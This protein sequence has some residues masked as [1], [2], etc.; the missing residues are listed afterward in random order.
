[1]ASRDDSR[2]W[3]IL[4]GDALSRLRD[5]PSNSV[6]CAVT[7]PP[8]WGLRD[9]GIEPVLWPSGWRGCFGL[10]PTP[11]LYL[12]H[13]VFI[14]RE[15]RR[16][17]RADGT[18]WV[19]MGDSYCNTDKWGGGKNGNTGKHSIAEDGSVPSW[20]VRSK[21]DPIPG[22]K[23]KDLVGMPWMLAFALRADG[24][25]LRQDIIWAKPNPMPE[26]VRDRCTKAHEYLFLLTKSQR[27]H[28]DAD[29]IREPL[30]RHQ[31]CATQPRC[32]QA[33]RRR[34]GSRQDERHHESC[35]PWNAT[36]G[37]GSLWPHARHKQPVLRP[38]KRS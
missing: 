36:H 23:P 29:A 31:R 9:Y 32:R 37:F 19:N 30:T 27:Y 16:A 1:M 35:V 24:W 15:V 14:F 13:A 7:S 4:E 26:S 10:E 17:L 25:Y 6:H 34:S 12:E 28:Y 11:E 21:K 2:Q 3:E 22:I 33:A 8:Y 5:L 20:T 18:C 38:R